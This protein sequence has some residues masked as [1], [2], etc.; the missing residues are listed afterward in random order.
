MATE[1]PNTPETGLP[2]GQQPPRF[3]WY[4]GATIVLFIGQALIVL[5]IIGLLSV[6][7]AHFVKEPYCWWLIGIWV[8]LGALLVSS[9]LK[10]K[11]AWHH[12]KYDPSRLANPSP[13][14]ILLLT[15]IHFDVQKYQNMA[16]NNFLSVRNYKHTTIFLSGLST[17]VLGVNFEGVIPNFKDVY[18]VYAKNIALIIGAIITAYTALTTYWN[19]EKYWLIN[20]TIANKLKELQY[21]VEDLDKQGPVSATALQIEVSKYQA[22]KSDFNKYWDGALSGKGS[23]G[24]QK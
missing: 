15:T 16:F 17:V 12:R 9:S 18:P 4:Q 1:Q 13:Q 22:I 2:S 14:L 11:T 10:T 23:E 8:A 19:I 24:G 20:K 3:N 21:E 6:A 7:T 5:C